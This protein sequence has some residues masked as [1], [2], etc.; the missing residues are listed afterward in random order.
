MYTQ[1]ILAVTIAIA[2]IV[3]LIWKVSE[4][5]HLAEAFKASMLER[6]DLLLTQ[7]V[8]AERVLSAEKA[9]S[10][11]RGKDLEEERIRNQSMRQE[12]NN[13]I[14][15]VKE[16]TQLSSVKF[17][18]LMPDGVWKRTEF[19]LGEGPCGLTV[20]SLQFEEKPDRYIL[21]Q[22]CEGGERKEFTYFREEVRGRI[23]RTF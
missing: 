7:R 12:L 18:A 16:R 5:H 2:I 19:K 17:T 20:I 3:Y 10:Y 14:T 4:E 8:E 6:D 22:R 9:M 21:T 11:R 1:T 15:I 23:E 13:Y